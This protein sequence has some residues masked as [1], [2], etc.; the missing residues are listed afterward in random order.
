MKKLLFYVTFLGFYF[1][2]KGLT[3]I[4]LS[5]GHNEFNGPK[6][7]CL[8]TRTHSSLNVSSCCCCS[9]QEP[10]SIQTSVP[11]LRH[12]YIP[13]SMTTNL[14]AKIMAMSILIPRPNQRRPRPQSLI[15]WRP[16]EGRSEEDGSGN[17]CSGYCGRKWPTKWLRCTET[18][19]HIRIDSV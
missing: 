8:A 16:K 11:I 17:S 13:I 5:S 3:Q 14:M 10:L 19:Q 7:L 1:L 18:A 4:V 9:L 15:N 2:V 6:W 12:R